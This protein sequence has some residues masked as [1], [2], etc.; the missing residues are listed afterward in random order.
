MDS[1]SGNVTES[2]SLVT[3][4]AMSEDPPINAKCKDKFLVCSAVIPVEKEMMPLTELVSAEHRAR[5]R[6][7][8]LIA[9]AVE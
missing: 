9:L 8:R 6:E 4:L 3:L 5:T 7:S 1:I 2:L